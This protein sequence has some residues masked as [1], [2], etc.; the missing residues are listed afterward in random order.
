MNDEAIVRLQG[1]DVSPRRPSLKDRMENAIRGRF[2]AASLPVVIAI[3]ALSAVLAF[4]PD[5]FAAQPTPSRPNVL[6]IAIDDLRNDLGC[7]GAKHAKTPQLDAFAATARVFTN[8]YVQVPTCGASRRALLSGR[9][10]DQPAHVNNNAIRSTHAE[11]ADRSLPTWLKQQGYRTLALGKIGHYPGGRTGK[12]W[13]EGPEELPGAWERCWIPDTPWKTAEAMMHAYANG[14][15]RTPGQ[16]P[17]IEAFDGKDDA[18]PDYWIADEAVTTLRSLA[19]W[20]E[21]WFFAVGLFKPHLPFNAPKRWFDLHAQNNI[22]APAVTSRPAEPTGW[23]RS[24]EFRGNYKD[25]AGRDPDNDPAYALEVRRAYAAATSYVDAQA[26]R[27]LSALKELGL[28]RNTIVVV[29]GDHG[30][31]LGEHAIW[32]KHCLY[33]ESLRAPLL[34]RTPGLAD[35]GAKSSAIVE[36]VDI[37]P[38]LVELC[39]LPVP[40]GVHGR[41][42]R[43]Q[44]ANARAATAKPAHGFWTERQRAIRT[45]RWRLIAHGTKG[46]GGQPAVELFDMRADPNEARNVAADNAAV[47]K[48]LLAQLDRV[49]DPWRDQP[50][51]PKKKK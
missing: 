42:L 15:R 27:V 29:W 44:L 8:H 49:P 34:I 36:T 35:A 47:V 43:P 31:L 37:L 3:A 13:T 2:E 25:P 9:Y 18:Y 14:K 48:D 23:H 33:E 24:G 10:P 45:D 7:L 20:K 17:P 19:T 5:A 28:E 32:G 38:T 39:G 50:I 51:Q 4:A 21:P 40:Q 11:W 22:P 46:A 6:F 1:R 41:S 26:G 30:F 16:V 12:E